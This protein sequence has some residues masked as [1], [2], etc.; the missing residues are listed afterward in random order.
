MNLNKPP[1]LYSNLKADSD[2]LK[3]LLP[4]MKSLLITLMK[5]F[6]TELKDNKEELAKQLIDFQSSFIMPCDLENVFETVGEV[7]NA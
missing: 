4:S 7:T 3:N 1:L 2:G 6:G 5:I